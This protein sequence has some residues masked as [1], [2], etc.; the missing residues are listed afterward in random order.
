VN[1]TSLDYALVRWS[2]ETARRAAH[3][4]GDSAALGPYLS[5]WFARAYDLAGLDSASGTWRGTWRR[6][7]LD[8]DEAVRIHERSGS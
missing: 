6:G 2:V 1:P 5:G 4:V 8:A 3:G 7:W